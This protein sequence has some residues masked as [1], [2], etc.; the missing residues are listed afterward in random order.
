MDNLY[1]I[2]KEPRAEGLDSDTIL[3]DTIAAISYPYI[4]TQQFG[5]IPIE[6]RQKVIQANR[7]SQTNL[8]DIYQSSK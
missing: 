5:D 6:Y 1:K 4:I 2:V 3:R 7:E 8:L